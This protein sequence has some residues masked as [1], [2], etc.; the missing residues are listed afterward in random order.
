MLVHDNLVQ[1]IKFQLRLQQC[2]GTFPCE[3]SADGKLTVVESRS[4]L[5]GLLVKLIARIVYGLVLWIQLIQ[6]RGNESILISLESLVF[7]IGTTIFCNV[8]WVFYQRREAFA[9]LFNLFLQFEKRHA[10]G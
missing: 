3:F 4:K 8:T 10:K 6:E 2:Q 5:R 1:Y 7:A 9:W